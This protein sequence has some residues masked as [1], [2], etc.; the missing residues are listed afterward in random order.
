MYG[1]KTGKLNRRLFI[2]ACGCATMAFGNTPTYCEVCGERL[3]KN[4]WTFGGVVC[5]SQI[6]VDKLRPVCCVCNQTI[7]G[8]HFSNEGKIYCSQ[9]CIDTTLPKCEICFA[10]IHNGYE[11]A[12]H[13]YCADCVKNCPNCFSC[14]LP[15]AHSTQLADGREICTT[16]MRWA[17]RTQKHAQKN[18]DM[19][20]RHLQAWTKLEL[21]SV[22]KLELV[23]RTRMQTLSQDLRKTDT[24]VSIRG[25]YSRQV[26]VTTHTNWF[27]QTKRT[28]TEENETIY[29]VDHLHDEVFRAAAL[30]EL[31]HDMIH[32][33]FPRLEEAPLWVQEGICQQAAAEYARRRNYTDILHGIKECDDPD[34]GDGYRYI[35]R[36]TG[37]EGW[38]ALKRWMETVNV[39]SLPT[40][41]PK[42]Y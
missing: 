32:E 4:Y 28:D 5:C 25:L 31:M 41:A 6:C 7:F 3:P 19:A 34:Y 40:E 22:P 15:A 12:H 27:G 38:S 39:D 20:L 8:G 13:R 18:Y 21:E 1:A 11:V 29:I 36:L 16:C 37:I 23:D 2:G 30:H 10:P 42:R 26:T 9:A 17:V 14:G 33:H 35:N 24:P